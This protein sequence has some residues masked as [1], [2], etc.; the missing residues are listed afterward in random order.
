MTLDM[1]L[2]GIQRPIPLRDQVYDVLRHKILNGE[3]P[4]GFKLV[5]E[6]LATQ[7]NVSRTPVREAIQRL[8]VEGLVTDSSQGHARVEEITKGRIEQAL[9]IRALLETYAC[10]HAAHTI[11]REQLD[12][13]HE[14]HAEEIRRLHAGDL[15]I[16]SQ[17]NSA[18]HQEIVA[19]AG[20][21]V[22][23][24]LVKH[25]SA[26]VPSY[27]L[28]ALGDSDN[29]QF[30]VHSHGRIINSLEQGDAEAAVEEMSRHVEM[31]RKVMSETFDEQGTI[32]LT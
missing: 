30:F 24:H 8:Q 27:R 6:Q 3:F 5:E 23:E 17:L 29:L 12:H 7:L 28:F 4:P 15:E 2:Q 21:Q 10:R 26:H 1:Q 18:I 14:L 20:N 19:A 22:L 11:T 16:M 31:A 13:L 32:P 25:L 9:D